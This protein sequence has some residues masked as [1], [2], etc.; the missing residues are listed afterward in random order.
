MPEFGSVR[1]RHHR[2]QASHSHAIEDL[3]FIRETME[4]AASFTAVPGWGGVA[5]G[6][7]ALGA[8]PLATRQTSPAAWLAVWGG[9]AVLATALGAL[10]ILWKARKFQTPVLSR[11]GRKFVLSLSPPILAAAI[12]TVVVYRTG[13]FSLLPGIWLLLY[14]AG[15]VTGGTFSVKVV[16]VM[17]LCFMLVGI[18]ALFCP[19]AWGNLLMASGFGGLHIIFGILIAWRYG[20]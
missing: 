14:G 10:G 18:L 2:P 6:L 8:A 4:S 11:P 17:G 9:A 15:V 3:R 7:T 16:P 19:P 5:M 12:L 13:G 1:S 20:G